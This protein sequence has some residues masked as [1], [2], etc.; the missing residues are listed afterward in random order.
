M[1]PGSEPE[2]E[3]AG[4]A[5]GSRVGGRGQEVGEGKGKSIENIGLG[6]V[7]GRE[8]YFRDSKNH[9]LPNWSI[10][11]GQISKSKA[12]LVVAYFKDCHVSFKLPVLPYP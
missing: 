3:R 5:S 2:R 7:T 12:V 4:S 6:K 1:T 8:K 10:H 9:Q 11:L